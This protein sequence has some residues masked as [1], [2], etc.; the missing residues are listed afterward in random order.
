MG[1]EYIDDNWHKTKKEAKTEPNADNACFAFRKITINREH[2]KECFSFTW[3]IKDDYLEPEKQVEIPIK[4][5]VLFKLLIK[6]EQDGWL[7]LE[8]LR[9]ML[10]NETHIDKIYLETRYNDTNQNR[11]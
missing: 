4:N 3:I 7:S 10:N 6:A 1:T 5:D 11:D 8:P 9:D 2:D